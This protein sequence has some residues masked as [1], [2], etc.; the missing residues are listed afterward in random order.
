[1]TIIKSIIILILTS[2]QLFPVERIR[3]KMMEPQ[4]CTHTK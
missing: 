2:S 1:L 3:G 4:T